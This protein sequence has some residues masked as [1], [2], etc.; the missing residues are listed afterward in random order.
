MPESHSSDSLQKIIFCI[1]RG[2]VGG[3]VTVKERADDWQQTVPNHAIWYRREETQITRARID[4]Q[5]GIA[6]SRSSS[7]ARKPWEG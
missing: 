1:C 2:W 7:R 6:Q 4:N 3:S 5:N